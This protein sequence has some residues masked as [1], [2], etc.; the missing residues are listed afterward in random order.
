[1]PKGCWVASVDISDPEAFKSYVKANAEPFRQY[2]ARFVVLN[3]RSEA[4]E[5]KHRSQTVVSEFK[6]YE[7]AL[8]C[9]RS[10]ECTAAIELRKNNSEADV[11][12]VEGY[13]GP[14]PTD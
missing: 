11:L 1:M 2:G 9:Y 5:G 10:P 13:D 3:G 12:I 14:P 4:V 6:D 8:A 7:T